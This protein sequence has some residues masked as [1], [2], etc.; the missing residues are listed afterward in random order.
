MRL[1]AISVVIFSGA[2]IAAS[3]CIGDAIELNDTRFPSDHDRRFQAGIGCLGFGIFFLALELLGVFELVKGLL[4]RW[5][6]K[7]K[8][9]SK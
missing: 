9:K 6:L 5:L 4:H 3:V 8:P 7:E 1:F 2:L